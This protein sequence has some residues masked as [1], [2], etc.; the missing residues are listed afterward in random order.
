VSAGAPIADIVDNDPL[1]LERL[2]RERDAVADRR[3]AAE[4]GLT[5]AEATIDSLQASMD[6]A[7]SNAELYVL[8]AKEKRDQAAQELLAA[9]AA[10]KTALLNHDRQRDLG[11]EGLSSSRK[12]ELADLKLAT[13]KS[14]ENA[15]KAKLRAAEK[16][17]QASRAKLDNIRGKESAAIA[18]AREALEKQRSEVAKAEEDG[19]KVDAKVSRQESMSVTA[20]I[21]GTILRLTANGGGQFVKPGDVIAEI[22]PDTDSRA[23]E[24]WVSGNDMPLVTRGRKVRLQFEGWPA[25]QFVGWPSIAVGTFGGVVAFVD[26]TDNGNGLFRVVLAPDPDDEPWPETRFLRQ[27]VRTKGWLLLD[28]VTVAFELWRQLNGFP[29]SVAP[30]ENAEQK[31]DKAK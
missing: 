30:P 1:Y 2:E 3:R 13:T 26:A 16:E 28:E 5:M 14:K 21:T 8:I 23:V 15:A 29:P 6:G 10:H 27:G 7:V 12:V 18:K 4:T 22:V 9:E 20:P 19:A 24:L 11:T 31:K 25:V 17:I